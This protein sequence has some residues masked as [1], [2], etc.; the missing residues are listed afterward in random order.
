MVEKGLPL[1]V[2]DTILSLAKSVHSH[3]FTVRGIVQGGL[4]SNLEAVRSDLHLDYIYVFGM[5]Q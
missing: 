2:V 3:K 1:T 5:L 4:M